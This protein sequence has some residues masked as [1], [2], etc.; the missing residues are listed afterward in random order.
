MITGMRTLGLEQA[1]RNLE[2][3]SNRLQN[4]IVRASLRQGANVFLKATRAAT[5]GPGRERRTGLLARSQS[6][7][8][9]KRGDVLSAV[10]R[11]RDVNVAPRGAAKVGMRAFYWWFL[12]KG[13]GERRTK[14]G[15]SRGSIAAR[16]WVV[17]AFEGNADAAIAAF[18][19]TLT[20]RL[21]E[22]ANQLPKG[23][24]R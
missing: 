9:N 8:T 23:V 5:Y 16:P 20:Q 22:A 1:R 18:K 7:T 12:E 3:L 17:P 21:E 15:A 2:E 6:V 10:V 24:S 4:T 19:T 14:K 11:M 13:T